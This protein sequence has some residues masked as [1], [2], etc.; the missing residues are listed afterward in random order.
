MKKNDL[1]Y[2]V[3]ALLF[4]TFSSVAALGLL[5]GF[6]IPSGRAA[7][8]ETFFLGLHR[9]AWGEFHLYLALCFLGLLIVHVSLSWGW[10][11]HSTKRF[12]GEG[13][14]KALLVLAC[15]WLLVVLI[16]WIRLRW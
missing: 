10:V 2:L 4:V 1:K 14:K 7:H 8:G 15:S 12:F 9:H 16:G 5:L 6:V 11:V 13:W 3:D